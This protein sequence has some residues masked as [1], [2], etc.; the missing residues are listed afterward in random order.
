MITESQDILFDYPESVATMIGV[1]T[2]LRARV[3]T[4]E[5]DVIDGM[6]VPRRFTLSA[7]PTSLNQWVIH[8]DRRFDADA[9]VGDDQEQQKPCQ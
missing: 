5:F 3:A 9:P 4:A 2:V 7:D 1:A 8:G 6:P